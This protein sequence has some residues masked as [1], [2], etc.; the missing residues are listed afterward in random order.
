V[1]TVF[2]TVTRVC[3]DNELQQ[4]VELQ[5]WMVNSANSGHV[6]NQHSVLLNIANAFTVPLASIRDKWHEFS[7][8]LAPPTPKPSGEP[9]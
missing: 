8:A 1:K 2:Y 3:G 5:E 4:H 6:G 7:F 9:A